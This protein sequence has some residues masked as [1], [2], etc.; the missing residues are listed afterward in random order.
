[1]GEKYTRCKITERQCDC[2][3]LNEQTIKNVLTRTNNGEICKNRRISL[4]YLCIIGAL[5]QLNACQ[6]NR[7]LL[8][9][10]RGVD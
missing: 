3:K 1:V 2:I 8:S 5:D 10:S 7:A 4:E 6:I 9:H